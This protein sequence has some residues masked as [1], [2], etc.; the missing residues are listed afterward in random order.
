MDEDMKHLDVIEMASNLPWDPTKV[1]EEEVLAKDAIVISKVN[2]GEKPVPCNLEYIIPYI[3]WNSINIIKK[4]KAMIQ[5]A[6]NYFRIS[7]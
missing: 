7:I 6:K 5:N 4:V 1:D 3:G 2:P